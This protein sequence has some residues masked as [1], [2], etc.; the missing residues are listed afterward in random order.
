MKG[1]YK[2]KKRKGLSSILGT[3]IV[4]AITL[5]LGGLLYAYSNGLFS[6]LTQN[7]SL[8]TQLS[9][10]V[11]PNT[12]QA[13]LQYYISNTG[14]TQIYLNSIVILNGTKNIVISLTN[15]LLQ[16]GESI[17]NITSINGKIT[18]GQYYTVEIVGNLPNGKPYS[19]VQNVLA[20]IA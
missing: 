20:S 8:Q 5:V 1:V 4:L 19:V 3:V 17:Q 15:D 11:N 16:P 14:N 6:S 7:T 2:L 9:I 18:A 10:Y 13:Y 12:G